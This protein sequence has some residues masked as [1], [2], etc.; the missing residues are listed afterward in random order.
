MRR[1][2]SQS[3][4]TIHT[5]PI[6]HVSSPCLFPSGKPV[7]R[8]APHHL[9]SPA[10]ES[11]PASFPPAASRPFPGAAS[12]DGTRKLRPAAR[13]SSSGGGGCWA[14]VSFLVVKGL[15]MRGAVVISTGRG[16]RLISTQ[17]APPRFQAIP[18]RPPPGDADKI[19]K[20]GG[21]R[22]QGKSSTYRSSGR[23]RTRC[24]LAAAVLCGRSR[25]ELP[26][27]P[28]GT[29]SPWRR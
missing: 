4:G 23:C 21:Q 25:G 27:L 29:A 28:T 24:P 1:M 2:L 10:V 7:A 5:Q 17:L 16:G 19:V 14:A 8:A 12:S 11:S 9:S 13:R 20:P 15:L 18:S 3:N 22:R 26:C 6:P